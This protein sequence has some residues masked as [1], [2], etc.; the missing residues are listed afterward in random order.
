MGESQRLE[1]LEN[2]FEW[3]PMGIAVFDR[4]LRLRES[5]ATWNRF[6]A[7]QTSISEPPLQPGRHLHELIPEVVAL[8][9][10]LF[11]RALTGEMVRTDA[12]AIVTGDRTSYWDMTLNPLVED[13]QITGI[14]HMLS[15]VTERVV[16][17]NL[18]H[19]RHDQFWHVFESTSDAFIIND[20]D[21]GNVVEANSAACRMHGY[22]YDEFIGLHPAQF[23]HS[24]SLRKFTDYVNTVREGGEFRAVARDIRKDGSIFDVEVAGAG[25]EFRGR[26]HLVAVVR[27]I[28][29]R[30]QAETAAEEHARLAVL[31]ERV[32]L[33][34]TDVAD[35]QETL[36]G[37]IGAIVEE[38]HAVVGQIW[39]PE[40]GGEELVLR[41]SAGR[42]I[43]QN[44]PI[45]PIERS[46][47]MPGEQRAWAIDNLR[48]S[49]LIT[50]RQWAAREGIHAFAG[51]PMVVNGESVGIIGLFLGKPLTPGEVQALKAIASQV[52]VGIRRFQAEA[53]ARAAHASLERRIEGRTRELRTLLGIAQDLSSTIEP[54][55][56]IEVILERLREVVD[57]NATSL[58]LRRGDDLVMVLR[59]SRE[60]NVQA[61]RTVGRAVPIDEADPI[62]SAL[63]RGEPAVIT[64]VRSDEPLAIAYRAVRGV[65]VNSTHAYVR[66]WMAVPLRVKSE[67]IGFVLLSHEQPG[68]FGPDEVRMVQGFVAHASIAIEN[69]RLFAEE[70]ERSRELSTILDIARDVSST[71][72]L[73]PLL[74]VILERTRGLLRATGVSVLVETGSGELEIVSA[75]SPARG[76]SGGDFRYPIGVAQ[77]I[78][79]LALAGKPIIIDDVRSDN[80]LAN[81][82]R[83]AVGSHA[84]STFSMIRAWLAVPLEHKGRVFGLLALSSDTPGF[85]T[86]HD[87]DLAMAVASQ[88]SG[89]LNHA[90]LFAETRDRGNELATL[91]EVARTVASTLELKPL[92]GLILQ[93]LQRTIPFSKAAIYDVHGDMLRTLARQDGNETVYGPLRSYPLE[94][95]PINRFV[96]E[97]RSPVIIDDMHGPSEAATVFRRIW[98]DE[99]RE[100]F[101]NS[102]A[103]MGVPLVVRDE[104]IGML[105][106]EHHEAGK[107][108]ERDS[109]LAVA[110]AGQA[111]V[112]VENA[113]LFRESENRAREMGALTRVAST[114]TF[115]QPATETLNDLAARVVDA[116]SGIACSI[117]LITE[118]GEFTHTG[119]LGLPPG[120]PQAFYEAIRSGAASATMNAF[121]TGRR[122][123]V[124]NARQIALADPAYR[125]AHPLLVDAP[126]DAVVITP[127]ISRGQSLGTLDVYYPGGSNPD[128][129]E[130]ALL[131]AIADQA[132]VAAD[133]IRLF[134]ETDRSLNEARALTRVASSLTFDRT[135]EE[136]LDLLADNVVS[137][138][139]AVSAALLVIDND[140]HARTVGVFGLPAGYRTA[141]ITSWSR[142]SRL[143][144]LR[145]MNEQLPVV[146]RNARANAL[147]DVNLKPI[148]RFMAEVAWDS[149]LVVPMIYRGR[150]IGLLN[151]YYLPDDTPNEAEIELVQAIGGQ[152]AVA[153]ENARLFGE[154]DRK[155]RE[156]D[157]LYRADEQLL[158]SLRQEDVFEALVDVAVSI[159]DADRSLLVVYDDT[160]KRLNLVAWRGFDY[161]PSVPANASLA[162]LKEEVINSRRE[163]LVVERAEDQPEALQEIIQA[164]G[165]RSFIDVP[166]IVDGCVFGVFSVAW[167]ES[168]TF[169]KAEVRLFTALAQRAGL[170]L[171]NARLHTRA[172]QAASLEERQRLA[173]E[174]HDS[175]SQALYGI[176]LGTRTARTLLERDAHKAGEPLDYVLQ[177]AEAGLAELRALIFELR[178]ESLETEGIVAAFQKQVAAL[179]ARHSIEVYASLGEEPD[180]PISVKE[181]L[182]RIGQEALHNTV[183]HARATQVHLSL[184]VSG[185]LLVLEVRD[186]GMGFDPNEEF[187]GHL[188][189]QSMRE[190]ARAVGG[191]L[192]ISSARGAGTRVRLE[193]QGTPG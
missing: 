79:D 107:F 51:Y 159:A 92:L 63:A 140:Y 121:Q 122:R 143:D 156:L 41:A 146:V 50:D 188:G 133:N 75:R 175:V 109:A 4:E 77:G 2:I 66:A 81:G 147:A 9:Q 1:L 153:I 141:I 168:R 120:F 37:C 130:L 186:N 129:R 124:K 86:D 45:E 167:T 24:E 31:G 101:K 138:T 38:L 119:A 15:D 157:A 5:N 145:A 6:V 185:Q 181:V 28:T 174:L 73:E 55:R 171:Q 162:R 76:S 29:A 117:N 3:M 105:T 71:L 83:A 72:E 69:A 173:R 56:L 16:A 152:A 154:T 179:V 135:L 163:P 20:P 161:D 30:R 39:M 60:P 90:R 34:L 89:A 144:S 27:D 113:R 93:Q 88:V 84:D 36:R 165:V 94:Q 44:G 191:K 54:A 91:L 10:P 123:V 115:A 151:A 49:R 40:D 125:M 67:T 137:A 190:R 13:G 70:A 106:L 172:Q 189:L 8:L 46:G 108:T 43:Q 170:A 128:E 47:L 25:L 42:S 155:V 33:S 78:W 126:W 80:E 192:E 176:G 53:E 61:E 183:K 21:T 187:P 193:L 142:Q 99:L 59:W 17:A 149:V 158:Q 97:T 150:T 22:T 96:I 87:A 182:Y 35:L 178:P 62:W 64:D 112:A 116:T 110:F 58:S 26:Q 48:E 11:N 148:H 169:T 14:V 164:A 111:A 166:I 19:Q 134:S 65:D 136:T 177:L 74:D 12:A 118:S 18:A 32:G 114:L 160:P 102:R 100:R 7:T 52:A 23:I 184:T 127:L 85:F 104:A 180:I 131:T 57:C 68:R 132:A 95:V 82:F 103:W 98:D 139:K